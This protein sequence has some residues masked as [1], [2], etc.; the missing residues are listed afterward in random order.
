[1]C[2]SLLTT[3]FY[4]LVIHGLAQTLKVP[5]CILL[6]NVQ[7]TTKQTSNFLKYLTQTGLPSDLFLPTSHL[8]LL[9]FF[10]FCV[11][12]VNNF[13]GNLSECL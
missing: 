8:I 5:L 13:T 2:N 10:F 4:M 3:Y 1:M 11:F 9:G 7:Q 6:S 12:S